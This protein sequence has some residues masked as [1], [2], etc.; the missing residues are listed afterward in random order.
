MLT[1]EAKR[2]VIQDKIKLLRHFAILPKGDR[3]TKSAIIS[4]LAEC[5]TEL[6][7]ERCLYNVL[8]GSENLDQFL[9][10]KYLHWRAGGI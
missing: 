3:E 5:N 8:H 10:R 4:V 9:A 6:E 7:M 2:E 1:L